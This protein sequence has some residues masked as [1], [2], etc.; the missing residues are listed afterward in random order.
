M[1]VWFH[2]FIGSSKILRFQK[3]FCTIFPLSVCLRE[4]VLPIAIRL[5][6]NRSNDGR[7]DVFVSL[8]IVEVPSRWSVKVCKFQNVVSNR[9]CEYSEHIT[10]FF[11][12]TQYAS[13]AD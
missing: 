13:V 2:I 9:L 6:K 8:L 7:I 10:Y 1:V 12:A 4:T 11:F 3:T 5:K